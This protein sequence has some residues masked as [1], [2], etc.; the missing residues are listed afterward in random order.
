[1][2]MKTVLTIAGSDPSGGAGIQSD[3]RTLEAFRVRGLSA[4][5]AITAQNSARVK[6]VLPVPGRFLKEQIELLLEE[7][8]IDAAKTGMI[9]SIENLR[10]LKRLFR[11]KRIPN[12]VIDTVLRSTSGKPLIDRDGVKELRTILPYARL[13]TPNL[14]EAEAL[15]GLKTID[16][17]GMERAAKAI[18]EMGAANVLVKGGHLDGEPIDILYDGK[19]FTYFR[20]K[21]IKG[22]AAA[23]HGTGCVLSAAIAANLAKGRSVRT[24]V[25]E[26]KLFVAS[27]LRQRVRP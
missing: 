22:D 20:G 1:M 9:G 2:T 12:L 23:F 24:A 11:A 6:S 13:V 26:A 21:R 4:I 27:R 8:T 17:A 18:L 19:S 15:T 25:K 16:A 5:T 14:P 3:L 7:F 10:V